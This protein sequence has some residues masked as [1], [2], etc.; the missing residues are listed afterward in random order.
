MW[1]SVYAIVVLGAAGVLAESPE[2]DNVVNRQGS[3]EEQTNG[4]TP[5]SIAS[6]VKPADCAD[7]LMGGATV[8]GVYEIY[9]FTCTCGKPVLVWCDME[10]DGGGWTVFLNRQQQNVQLDFNLTWDHYKAGFGSPYSEYYL[11][12]EVLHQMTNGR[13]YVLRLDLNLTSGGSDFAT[14]DL[15]RVNSESNRYSSYLTGSLRGDYSTTNCLRYM[16]SRSFTT[17]DRD[18][19]SYTGNCASVKGGAWWYYNCRTFN[20]TSVYNTIL[21]VTCYGSTRAVTQLQLK[22]RPSIC[23]SSVKTIHATEMGCG[24]C[25]QGVAR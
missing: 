2:K 10:T 18:H 5:F 21:N 1:V 23:D 11:G 20:P 17:L 7:H 6:V 24:K 16:G 19:D 12:N 4:T 25:A 22:I 9:P 15:F 3:T 13:S 8:S 14:Y